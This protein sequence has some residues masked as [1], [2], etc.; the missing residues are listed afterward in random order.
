[1]S[2]PLLTAIA[3][4]LA[5]MVIAGAV[6][7]AG[8]RDQRAAILGLLI[9]LVSSP[10]LA[11]PLPDPRGILA[12]LAGAALVAYLLLMATRD[13]PDQPGPGGMG[14]PATALAT[15][16]AALVVAMAFGGLG[17]PGIPVPAGAGTAAPYVPAAIAGAAVL[18]AAAAPVVLARSPLRLAIGLVLALTGGALVSASIAGPPSAF[19]DLSL[20]VLLGA[21]AGVGGFL[22]RNARP[23]RTQP[24]RR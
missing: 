2:G 8:L 9:A 23:T 5:V 14:W 16:T 11:D 17:G 20:A 4:I 24:A 21:L 22:Q 18:V 12:R 7:A 1:M 10:F 13:A 3:S 15:A 19:T 6:A